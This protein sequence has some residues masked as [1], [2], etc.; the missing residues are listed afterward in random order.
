MFQARSMI[1]RA[2][3]IAACALAG[4]VKLPVAAQVPRQP[5]NVTPEAVPNAKDEG[6]DPVF[7]KLVEIVS[8]KPVVTGPVDDELQSLLLARR[9]AAMRRAKVLRS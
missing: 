8:K 6:T 5:A 4:I 9:D 7:K 3:L 2:S 1:P